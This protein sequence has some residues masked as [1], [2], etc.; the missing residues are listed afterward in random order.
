MQ[1]IPER[2]R[3]L[4]L[5]NRGMT[6]IK[7]MSSLTGV[8]RFTLTDVLNGKRDVVRDSTYQK[9]ESWLKKVIVEEKEK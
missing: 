6:S 8:N 9:L 5:E 2:M 4:L 3:K 7:R 1:M